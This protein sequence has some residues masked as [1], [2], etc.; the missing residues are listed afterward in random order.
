MRL[1]HVHLAGGALHEIGQEL[2]GG[3]DR[4]AP[5]VRIGPNQVVGVLA[6]RDP[7]DSDLA[8]DGAELLEETSLRRRLAGKVHVVGEG[9]RVRIPIRELDLPGG[10]RGAQA[11]DD[12]L[13]ARLVRG[14]HIGVAL[15]DHGELLAPNRSLCQIDAVQRPALVE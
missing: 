13:E 9:D 2:L 12:V 15:D 14:H 1:P 8:H 10:E 7:D 11:G 5:A 6:G 4:C 3:L